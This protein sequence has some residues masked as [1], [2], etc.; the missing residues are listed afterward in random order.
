MS[1]TRRSAVAGAALLGTTL[2]LAACAPA[3]GTGQAA[4]DP[5]TGS[6]PVTGGT[7][8]FLESQI[9]TCLYAG[10]GGFYPNATLINQLGDKLTYQD[11]ETREITPWLATDWEVNADAT[12]Y[13]FT[14]RDDVTFSDGTPLTAEVVALNFDHFGL[15]DE[16]LG[17]T[18]QEFVSNYVASEVVDEHTVKFTFSAPSPGF[19]QATSVVGA[20]IVAEAT[21]TLPYEEQCQIENYVASGPFTVGDVQPEKQYDLVARDDYDWAPE[22]DEHQGRAY[23]DAISVIVTPEDNVRIGALTAGQADA[24]RAVQVYDIESIEASGSTVYY[25]PT[26]GVN[27]QFALRP[28]NPILADVRVRRALQKATDVESAVESIFLG[29]FSPATSVLSQGAT[30]YVDL[31]DKLGYD[32]DAAKDLLD[33]AGWTEGSDGIREKDGHKLELTTWPGAVFPLNQQLDEL[34]AE[35]W[36]LAGVQLNIVTPDAATATAGAKDP[37]QQPVAITHVGRVDPDVI[38][39]NFG[40]DSNRN[41]LGFTPETADATLDEILGDVRVLPTTEERFAKTAEAQEYLIDQAYV[42]PLYELPQ[43]YAAQAKVQGLGWEAVGRVDLT[44]AWIQR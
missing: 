14:L 32:L 31:S 24:I 39:S 9:P 8:T 30:G 13:V 6:Q 4:G 3:G 17:L 42:I 12:E 22:A 27:P 28:G 34:V 15:G 43:T 11:P 10:G 36:K 25:A 7:L 2:A 41:G 1:S 44:D 21:A 5:A 38:W 19:L 33:E 40:S 20:T 16:A 35:Q 26:N 37:I 23:L 18:K 29:K